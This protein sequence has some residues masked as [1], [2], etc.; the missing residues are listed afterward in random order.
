MSGSSAPRLPAAPAPSPPAPPP[1]CSRARCRSR[2][3]LV[4]PPRAPKRRGNPRP[5][6]ISAPGS[7]RTATPKAA[8]AATV[9]PSARAS[10]EISPSRGKFAGP[11]AT[12]NRSASISEPDPERP[13]QQPQQHALDAAAPA[14]FAPSPP[15]APRESPAPAA[16][17]PPAP[18]A[19]SRR[20][21]TR[22]ASRCPMVP[23]TTHS[24][25]PTLPTTSCFSGC[26]CRRDPPRSHNCA[27]WSPARSTMNSSRS[28]S[29]ARRRRWPLRSSLP[30]SAARC[31]L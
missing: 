6:R 14:R 22:S 8:K 3:T 7:I 19:D 13:A 2:L 17:P 15:P 11:I 21:R 26:K 10:S 1:G 23:I 9:N 12:R 18:A 30:A 20:W 31:P 24:T 16:A 4:D 5:R 28:A 27:D 25:A 29:S